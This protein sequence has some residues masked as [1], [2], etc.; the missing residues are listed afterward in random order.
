MFGFKHHRRDSLR[1]APLPQAWLKIIE[2]NVPFYRCLPEADQRELQGHI[3]VF[4]AE[5]H[6]EGCRGLQVTDEIKITI[7]A[8]ACLLLLHRDTDYYPTL[9]SILVYPSTYIAHVAESMGGIVREG[10]SVR[11]G[12]SWHH[13]A[14][15]LSWDDVLRGAADIHDGHNVVLHEFAHQLDQEGG[16]A[17]GSP[18]L[19]R[20]SMYVAWARI[21]GAEYAK[22]Q[23]DA[24][25]GR[26]TVLD[27]YGATNPAEFF[28]VATECFFEK[29]VQLKRKHPE[30]YEELKLYYQQDTALLSRH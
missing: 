18:I 11:L 3:Q 16:A 23:Q 20:R 15:V 22:L 13:G 9:S 30:L 19:P 6:F 26:K 28:A 5:K 12:E 17:H 7:A 29:A 4:L 2:D 27:K 1:T 10:D 21:L 8:Q 25:Y 24:E 14:V